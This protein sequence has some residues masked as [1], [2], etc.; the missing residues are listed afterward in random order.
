MIAR[1]RLSNILPD[2]SNIL[3]ISAS[4]YCG[5]KYGN[6]RVKAND[7]VSTIYISQLYCYMNN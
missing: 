1:R 3:P 5:D 6:A 2:L 7:N 4:V